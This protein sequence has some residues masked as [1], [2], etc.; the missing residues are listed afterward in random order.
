MERKNYLLEELS[1]DED[2][3]IICAIN[4]AFLSSIRKYSED[5]KIQ[6][7]GWKSVHMGELS[8]NE[9]KELF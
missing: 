2:K 6:I 8:V 3:Y 4:K 1:E 5:K 9:F 7:S